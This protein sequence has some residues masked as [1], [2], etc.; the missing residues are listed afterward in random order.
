MY[1]FRKKTMKWII[2]KETQHF[3]PLAFQLS[4][5]L[6]LH[7]VDDKVKTAMHRAVPRN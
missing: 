1:S 7:H 3:L 2:S 6:F 5:Y 4:G